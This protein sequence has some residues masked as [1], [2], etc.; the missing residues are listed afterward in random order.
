M[1]LPRRLF[2]QLLPPSLLMVCLLFSGSAH[3]GA[4]IYTPLS[5]SVRAVLQHA[6]SDQAVPDAVFASKAEES[7]WMNEMSHRMENRIPDRDTR[8]DFLK[9][10]HY[11]ATRAGLDPLMVLGLIEVESGFR[12]YAISSAGARGFMQVM[13]FWVKEIGARDDNL[14]HLRT[15]LRYGCTILRLYLDMENGNLYRALGRYNG[16]LGRPEYPNLVRAAWHKYDS[17]LGAFGSA[18]QYPTSY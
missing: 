6:V 16:S 10:V 9:T 18:K 14:F 2:Q 7:L 3:A 1:N 13:P 17:N 5:A 15:N 12:K 8:Q 11:E 4:Q